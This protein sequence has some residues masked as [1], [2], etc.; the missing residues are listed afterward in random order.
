VRCSRRDVSWSRAASALALFFLLAGCFTSSQPK[1]PLTTAVAAFG[2]G[3]RY[4]GYER[5]SDG[6]FKRDEAFNVRR[7]PDGAYDFVDAKGKVTTLSLHRIG[8]DRFVAQAREGGSVHY[9]ILQVRGKEVLAFHP[10]CNKDDAA[11]LKAQG[12][13]VRQYE[14]VIDGVTDPTALFAALHLGEPGSKMVRE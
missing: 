13:D 9:V 1:F 2:D 10:D 7:R 4:V 6:S 8:P 14:C 3:G 12:V 11:K 5:T